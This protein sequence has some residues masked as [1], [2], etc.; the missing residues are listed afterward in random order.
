MRDAWCVLHIA[1]KT[2]DGT[3]GF[4]SRPVGVQGQGCISL[5]WSAI[6][7]LM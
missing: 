4:F 6:V 1:E 7:F 5:M 2:K 3:A